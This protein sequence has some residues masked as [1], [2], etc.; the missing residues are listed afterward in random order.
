MRVRLINIG[1]RS[2][3]E[4]DP[5]AASIRGRAPTA[6]QSLVEVGIL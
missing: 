5:P 4:V 6:Y 2:P 3:A 1:A